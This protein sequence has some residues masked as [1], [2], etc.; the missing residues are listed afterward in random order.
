MNKPNQKMRKCMCY[1]IIGALLSDSSTVH[2]KRDSYSNTY[3]TQLLILQQDHVFDTWMSD[4]VKRQKE[5]L[6]LQF[7]T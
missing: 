4:Y 5:D 7:N 2:L 6:Y 1:G 3:S